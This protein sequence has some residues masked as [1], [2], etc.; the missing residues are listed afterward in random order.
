ML[1]LTTRTTPLV[2]YVDATLLFLVL[3][4]QVY[5]YGVHGVRGI[6][7]HLPF[8]PLLLTSVSCSLVVVWTWLLTYRE[9]FR[10]PIKT[11]KLD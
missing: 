8:L 5:Y 10:Q 7:A 3:V 11:T 4:T 9:F 6:L 2:S 1:A